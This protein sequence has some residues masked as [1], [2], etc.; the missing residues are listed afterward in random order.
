MPGR[1]YYLVCYDIVEPRRWRSCYKLLHGY[2]ER[3]QYSIFKCRLTDKQLAEMRWK[4]VKVLNK[5]E[6]KLMIS[7]IHPED[8]P[9]IFMLNMPDLDEGAADSFVLV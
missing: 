3:I 5:D 4:L 6:D 7:P 2:G 8:V 9:R 1:R